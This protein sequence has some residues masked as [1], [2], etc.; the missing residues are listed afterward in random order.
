MPAS[1]SPAPT[2]GASIAAIGYRTAAM[3]AA[4]SRS[5]LAGRGSKS[6]KSK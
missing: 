4:C 6:V 3:R 1:I 5:L 2:S